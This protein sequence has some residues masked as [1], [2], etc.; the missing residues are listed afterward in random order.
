M[1]KYGAKPTTV[2]GIKFASK[3]EAA[4]YQELLLRKQAGDIKDFTLQP[5]FELQPGFTKNGKKHR[6]IT[7]TADF[8]ITHNDGSLEVVDVKGV[9]TPVFKLKRKMFEFSF[10]ENLSVVK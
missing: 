9:E 10:K 5:T 8:A 1:T 7:Y 4:Y 2:D 6:P 3:K